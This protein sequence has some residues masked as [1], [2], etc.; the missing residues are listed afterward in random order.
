M[1]WSCLGCLKEAGGVSVSAR[2]D[3]SIVVGYS[4][5]S[6]RSVGQGGVVLCM[7]CI[8][9]GYLLVSPPHFFIQ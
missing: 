1:P 9:H 6:F 5:R 3:S 7:V 8:E 4:L 2:R